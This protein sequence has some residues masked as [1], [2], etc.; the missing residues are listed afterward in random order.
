MFNSPYPL[1]LSRMPTL[2]LLM[3]PLSGCSLLFSET[4]AGIVLKVGTDNTQAFF[5]SQPLLLDCW[6]HVLVNYGGAEPLELLV[7]GV[8]HDMAQPVLDI[9][10]KG[11]TCT[12]TGP[13]GQAATTNTVH[14]EIGGSSLENDLSF[15]GGVM[16]S[17]RYFPSRRGP[18]GPP[19][20]V[21][22]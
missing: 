9:D 11:V 15:A 18:L 4:S 12:A 8:A 2:L 22:D 16:D 10:G 3:A 7:N 1:R 20:G 21:C 13:A 5:C 19:D 14:V 6:N 17:L